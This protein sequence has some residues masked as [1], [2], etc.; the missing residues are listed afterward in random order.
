MIAGHG[1]APTPGPALDL[2]GRTAVQRRRLVRFAARLK[3]ISPIDNALRYHPLY[4]AEARR[5]IARFAVADLDGRRGLAQRWVQRTLKVAAETAHGRSLGRN[6]ADWP[7][8]DKTT[9][10]DQSKGFSR[11]GLVRV[12]AESSATTGLPVRVER[13]LRGVAAEQAFLDTLLVPHGLDF[14]KARIAVLRS[15]NVKP[16]ER[17]DPPF[18]FT[19]HGGKRLVLSSPHLGPKTIDWYVTALTDFA[20]DLIWVKP[21]PLA[22][23]LRLLDGRRLDLPLVL[24]S[25]EML[26]AGSFAAAQHAL[27]AQ[28]IDYYG[29]TERVVFAAA[30]APGAYRFEPA[31]GFVELIRD[32]ELEPDQAR[33]IA[34][35]YWND[36]M[37][38]VRYDT[39]DLALVP[40]DADEA[41]LERIAL[42]LEPFAGIAGRSGEYLIAP[43]GMQVSGVNQV[44]RYVPHVLQAQIYQPARDRAIIRVLAAPGFGE[45]ERARILANARAKIPPEITVSLETV[46]NLDTAA[47]GK[48]PFII[49]VE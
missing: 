28:V 41:M 21:T 47:N 37:P 24:S 9:L 2:A 48:T 5:A 19:D 12:P 27:S 11:S 22:N 34:T 32:P 33:I 36:A 30:T 40:E 25:S 13:D 46:A 49:R 3:S 1:T 44:T 29:Q 14:R 6:L 17:R 42:G 35:G 26:P 7:I 10:R 15:D 38:L 43:D 39:G 23:L 16:A 45:P 4:R 18:G 31:Y 20:P 8:V